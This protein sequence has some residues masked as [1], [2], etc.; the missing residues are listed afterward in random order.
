MTLGERKCGQQKKKNCQETKRI[1]REN[2]QVISRNKV[3]KKVATGGDEE[4]KTGGEQ[5]N[6]KSLSLNLN[7]FKNQGNF[8]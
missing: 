7:E 4:E 3:R 8:Y 1:K 6:V 2:G 5:K